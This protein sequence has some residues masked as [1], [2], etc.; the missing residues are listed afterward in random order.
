MKT[1]LKCDFCESPYSYYSAVGKMCQQHFDEVMKQ[2]VEIN[3]LK[4][5][6][7]RYS[8]EVETKNPVKIKAV[9]NG[10]ALSEL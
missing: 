2:V 4:P 5:F 7:G 6:N 10:T 1:A 3:K 8:V 9:Q